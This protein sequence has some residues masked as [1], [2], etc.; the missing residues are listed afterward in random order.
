MKPLVVGVACFGGASKVSCMKPFVVGGGVCLG[1]I[2]GFVHETYCC[3]W[4]LFWDASDASGMIIVVE[5]VA[6]VK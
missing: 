1:G 5:L 4:W 2:K 3:W 6:I